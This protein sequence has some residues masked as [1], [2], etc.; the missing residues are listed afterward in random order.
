M[1]FKIYSGGDGVVGGGDETLLWTEDRLIGGT[2]GVTITDGVFQINLGAVTSLPGSVDFN[3][4][5]LWLSMQLGNTSSCTITTTFLSN[6]SGDGEM[7]PMVR[8][9]AAPYAFNSDLLDGIDSS[10]FAQL[11]GTNTWSGTNTYNSQSTFN[12][13]VD[14]VFNGT[15]NISVTSDLAGSVDVLSVIATPSSTSGTTQGIL[16]Q[17]AN[18][19]NTNG[20]DNGI[21]INNADSD[22]PI[23]AALKIQNS[24]GGGYTTIIDN[25]G[26]LISSAELNLLDGHASALVDTAYTGTLGI[27]G[28]G[29][30]DA[31]S[32]GT[33]FGAIDVGSDSITTT[34]TIGTAGS[35][36]FTGAGGTFSS[37]INANGGISLGANQNITTTAGTGSIILNSTVSNASD[38]A[39]TINTS[40]TGGATDALAYNAINIPGFSPTNASGTDFVNGLNIGNLTDPGA[41]ITSTAFKLGTGWDVLF[42]GSTAGTSIFDFTNFDVTSAGAVSS[43]G[44]NSGTGLLQGTGGL[45]VTGTINLNASGSG[46]T[47]I[48]SNTA[49][50]ISF[51]TSGV[52]TTNNQNDIIIGGGYAS[53]DTTLSGLTLDSFS[54]FTEAAST[55]TATVNG[56]TIYYNSASN[57]VRGCIN[58]QWEDM[59]STASLGLQLFGVVP[60]SGPDPGNWIGINATLANN[61]PCKVYMGGT[62]ASI[63]WTGCTAFSGGRKIIVPAQTSDQAITTGAGVWAHVCLNTS[64]AVAITQSATETTL[65][66]TFSASAPILCLADISTTNTGGGKISEIY[67]TRTFTTTT[68][69][70]VNNVT[71]N[72]SVGWAVAQTTTAGQ[73]TRTAATAGLALIRGVF[74]AVTNSGTTANSM[75]AIIATTGPAYMKATAGTA[76]LY[77][78]TIGTAGYVTATT[79]PACT[80]AAYCVPGLSLSAF[81]STCA[82][83]ADSCRGSIAVNLNLR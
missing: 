40:Y 23:T 72:P 38:D 34:G 59:V 67:D 16:I 56:G 1:E 48:G 25:Q 24:G 6:C 30:L 52:T 14:Y 31:G 49:G 73:V 57:A 15:E 76:G 60:D 63:R 18:S 71:N 82:A 5:T 62:T 19:A 39:I 10:S 36:T 22:L 70:I 53:S 69:E 12:T 11:S 58:G 68:K 32:I 47:T 50:T 83:N 45:T 61:G 65:W 2:G 79:L 74:V 26:T 27:T 42:G 29:V 8:F 78:Q 13:D 4:S 80:S 46:T 7:S 35:T 17:Q 21:T 43:V 37:T 3:N 75:N 33:S 51:V 77:V 20:L 41:S 66:P 9:T 64:G 55:C 81:S 28:T 54:T 44:V